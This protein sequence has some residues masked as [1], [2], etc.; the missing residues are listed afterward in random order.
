MKD[1]F[2]QIFY[3]KET[4]IYYVDSIKGKISEEFE[5][6]RKLQA[7]IDQNKCLLC[8]KEYAGCYI[9]FSCGDIVCKACSDSCLKGNNEKTCRLCKKEFES[10]KE[11]IIKKEKY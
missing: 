7:I 10:Y 9:K 8:R 6:L 1:V 3:N 4:V 5:K 2:S 11:Y